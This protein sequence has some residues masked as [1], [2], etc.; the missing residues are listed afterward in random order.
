MKNRKTRMGWGED[1]GDERD[2][3]RIVG[4]LGFKNLGFLQTKVDVHK[5]NNESF[6]YRYRSKGR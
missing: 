6:Y 1:G 5:T 4:W 3:D 2:R